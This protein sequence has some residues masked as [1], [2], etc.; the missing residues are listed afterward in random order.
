M[1]RNELG[2]REEMVRVTGNTPLKGARGTLMTG[3]L[4]IQKRK[5]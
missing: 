4:E 3:T 1:K 2:P 5:I